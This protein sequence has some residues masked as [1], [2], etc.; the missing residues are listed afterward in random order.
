MYDEVKKN[1]DSCA[2]PVLIMWWLDLT[3]DNVTTIGVILRKS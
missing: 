2:N 1:S 3:I